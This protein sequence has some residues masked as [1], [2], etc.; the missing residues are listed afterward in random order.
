MA[1]SLIPIAVIGIGK[2][3]EQI[4][5]WRLWFKLISFIPAIIAAGLILPYLY[6]LLTK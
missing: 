2:G 4:E 5:K 1:L 3:Q 6:D